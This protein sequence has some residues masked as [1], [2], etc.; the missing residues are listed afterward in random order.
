MIAPS[1]GRRGIVAATA[2]AVFATQEMTQT[3]TRMKFACR[4]GISRAAFIAEIELV[5]VFSRYVPRGGVPSVV[6][7]PVVSKAIPRI[8]VRHL[9]RWK[10]ASTVRNQRLIDLQCLSAR[11][12]V[13]NLSFDTQMMIAHQ[14]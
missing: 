1:L 6:G 12:T 4:E 10:V 13:A 14:W 7:F 2:A 8:F 11:C 5:E 9:R 3:Q